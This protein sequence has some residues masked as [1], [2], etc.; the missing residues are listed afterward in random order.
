[1]FTIQHEWLYKQQPREVWEYLTQAEL[2]TQ[3]LMPNDFKAVAGHEFRFHTAPI[4]ELDMDG[5]F[6]CR[7]LHIKPFE[8]LSYSWK[9][10]PGNGIF[11]MDTLCA[12]TLIPEGTGTRL[13][14]HHSG[15]TQENHELFARMTEG[16][17][18]HIGKTFSLSSPVK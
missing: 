7:V 10:G 15:F 18:Y 11:T 17:L 2:I 16:W 4:P 3:W 12:W 9:G 14:L 1:M 13:K 5:I 8:S 6:Y